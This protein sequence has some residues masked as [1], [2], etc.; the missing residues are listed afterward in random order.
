MV[1]AAITFVRDDAVGVASEQRRLG[2]LDDARATV[3]RLMVLARRL[4]REY[5][6]SAHSYSVLSDAHNQIKKNAFETHDDN[7]VEEALVQAVEAAQRAL[8]LD[9][10]PI[11][12]RRHLEK[13][14]AQL[15]SIKADRKGGGALASTVIN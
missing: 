7:L 2:R 8:A 1:P 10:D 11:E 12:T 4:V 6:N 13:L 15:A 3:A 14:T 5:P 9:P